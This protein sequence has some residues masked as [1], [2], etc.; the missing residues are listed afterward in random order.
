MPIA[1]DLLSI[2]HVRLGMYEK[3]TVRPSISV[4]TA[5]RL[6]V[7]KLSQLDEQEHIDVDALY[8]REPLCIYRRVATG[9]ILAT[10]E[11][12]PNYPS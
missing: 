1:R 7:E 11:I 12:D 9:E 5:A 6:L 4:E 8:G 2:M 10:I 3:G